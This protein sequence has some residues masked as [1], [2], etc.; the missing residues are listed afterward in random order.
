MPKKTVDLREFTLLPTD[1]VLLLKDSIDTVRR[2]ADCGDLPCARDE[3]G[4]RRFRPQD[5]DAFK[6][7]RVAALR[8][9]ADSIEAA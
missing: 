9:K 1:V 7:K 8:A 4:R 3:Y 2:L 6:E 5:V